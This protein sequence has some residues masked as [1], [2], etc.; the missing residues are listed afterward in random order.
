MISFLQKTIN[1]QILKSTVPK[2]YVAVEIKNT[3]GLG[4]RMEWVLEVLAFCEER[5]LSPQ[6]RFTYPD[7]DQDYFSRFFRIADKLSP[8]EESLKFAKIFAIGE[9][10]LDRNYDEFLNLDLADYLIKKYL[11]LHDDIVKEV[12]GFCQEHFAGRTMLGVHY[13]GTDKSTEAGHV[14]Y[15]KVEENIAWYM[16]KNTDIDGLFISTDDHNFLEYISG[17]PIADIVISRED[18]FRSIDGVAVH[19]STSNRYE[20]NRDALINCLLLARCQGLIKSTSILSAWS[21]LFNPEIPFVMLNK[22]F[23]P[24]FPERDLLEKVQYEAL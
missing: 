11:V 6:F 3:I 12:D 15:E 5:N 8:G 19:F 2:G 23:I 17:R 16:E 9:L 18:S 14:S 21:L 22:P 7:S 10:G 20:I 1:K 13:R 24:Y 4:A